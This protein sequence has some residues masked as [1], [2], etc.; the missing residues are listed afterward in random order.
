MW[1]VKITANGEWLT[2]TTKWE[3]ILKLY[4]IDKCNVYCLLPKVTERHMKPLA[5]TG[6]KVNLAVQVTKNTGSSCEHSSQSR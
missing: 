5:L 4:E 3:D 2:S 1:G 6:M